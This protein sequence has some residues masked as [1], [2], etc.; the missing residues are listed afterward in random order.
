[1][2]TVGLRSP[3][4]IYSCVIRN[5]SDAEIDV[6]VHFSG[7]EDHHAEVADIEI[8]QGEEERVD[9]KEFTHGDS[10]G[11]YHKTVELIRA[12]KFDGST[13]ELKQPFDGV[14]APKKDWIFEITNDSIKSVDPA[15]K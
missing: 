2:A 4:A 14:T 10:D 11:K 6:Q 12:R 1:M 15:K 13:I 3:A 8:A 7:I 5:N 9:E